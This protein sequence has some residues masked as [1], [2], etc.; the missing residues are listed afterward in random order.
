MKLLQI[1]S[2]KLQEKYIS[3]S[4]LLG[5]SQADLIRHWEELRK[6]TEER[7]IKLSFSQRLQKFSR[8]SY[9]ILAWISDIKQLI[10]QDAEPETVLDAEAL[11]ERMQDYD[12]ELF[13]REANIT[14]TLQ[15]GN[16][17]VSTDQGNCEQ[18]S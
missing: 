18:V 14:S 10:S 9:D 6:L 2:T 3:Y 1:E 13:V 7:G 11:I 5:E 15:F 17:L 4:D 12:G 8:D 16:T